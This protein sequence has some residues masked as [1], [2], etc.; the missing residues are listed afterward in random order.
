V[1]RKGL[2]VGNGRKKRQATVTVEGKDGKE[3][4]RRRSGSKAYN[5]CDELPAS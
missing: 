2:L 1:R 5:L 4:V 3:E